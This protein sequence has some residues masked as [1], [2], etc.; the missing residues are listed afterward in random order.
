MVFLEKIFPEKVKNTKKIFKN[1][2]T[3]IKNKKWLTGRIALKMLKKR[4]C[5]K[6]MSKNFGWKV[7]TSKKME[8]LL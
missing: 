5:G 8:L 2:W 7:D 1:C 3:K 4:Q 6:L